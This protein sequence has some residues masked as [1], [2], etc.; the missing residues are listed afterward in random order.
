MEHISTKLPD[1]VYSSKAAPRKNDEE[2]KIIFW[3]GV[4]T[5]FKL[6]GMIVWFLIMLLTLL[7]IKRFF[8]LD[9]FPGYDSAIDT[10]YNGIRSNFGRGL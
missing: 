6:T 4:S 1:I 7:E 2:R 5:L 9:L 3:D 8:N 10:V